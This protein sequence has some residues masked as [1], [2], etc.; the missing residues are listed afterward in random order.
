DQRLELLPV[1]GILQLPE[2]VRQQDGIEWETLQAPPVHGGDR[3]TVT[4]DAD[5]A[6][7]PFLA[8]LDRRLQRA[9]LPQRELPLD[10]IDEVMQLAQVDTN[11]AQ[12]LERAAD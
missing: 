9:S 2:V 4:G 3:E 7:Q 10:H 11:D 1:A 12:P 5:E 6:H 8:R